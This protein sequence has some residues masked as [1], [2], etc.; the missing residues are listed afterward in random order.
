VELCQQTPNQLLLVQM[1]ALVLL[2]VA[3]SK[4]VIFVQAC[5]LTHQ[6]QN[7][8]KEILFLL[9]KEINILSNGNLLLFCV[10]FLL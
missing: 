10:C 6:H 2:S 1:F 9:V 7:V 5:S 8:I 3:K 4:L